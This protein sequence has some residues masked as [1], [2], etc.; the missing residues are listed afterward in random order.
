VTHQPTIIA[1]A[2]DAKVIDQYDCYAVID[3]YPKV[4]ATGANAIP[5]MI[6]ALGREIDY[7]ALM[8]RIDGLLLPGARTN[9][10]PDEY[11]ALPSEKTQPHDRQR[12][13]SSLPLIHAALRHGVPLFAICRGIQELNVALGGTLDAK[14]HEI[15]GRGDHRGRSH[16]D[17][18]LRYAI[19]QDVALRPGGLLHMILDE[20]TIRVNSVH[21]QAI[22]RLADRLE[23]EATAPDGTIEAVRV[24][25]AASFALGVQWHPEYWVETDR[26]SALLF[27]AFGKAA[28]ARQEGR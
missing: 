13:R 20:E 16:D 4:V 12:D 18:D 1:I 22:A 10:H 5:L 11:G 6:P 15:A 8:G 23:V 9:V 21:H 25:D 7:D 14:V 19:N 24:R 17:L 3:Y 26:P 2:T 27:A 28:R